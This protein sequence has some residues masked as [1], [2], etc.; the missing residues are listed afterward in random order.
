MIVLSMK[1][2]ETT[3]S[4]G[5]MIADAERRLLRISVSASG[6]MDWVHGSTG[7]DWLDE[8][9]EG[10]GWAMKKAALEQSASDAARRLFPSEG[11]GLG[12]LR[13]KPIL[14][15]DTRASTNRPVGRERRAAVVGDRLQ[16]FPSGWLPSD[17]C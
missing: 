5:F 12:D 10:N 16:N 2:S 11:L 1:Q 13:T 9:C 7:S 17:G 3:R 15:M 14:I 8:N 6:P 4:S